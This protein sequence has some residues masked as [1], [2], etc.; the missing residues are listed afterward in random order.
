MSITIRKF[1]SVCR[2]DSLAVA[3]LCLLPLIAV[4]APRLLAY[5]P[6]LAG[7]IGV[8]GFWVRY[9][10]WPSIPLNLALWLAAF[11]ALAALSSL[12]A[13]DP[14]FALERSGKL[15]P[16][17]LGGVLVVSFASH[18]QPS[19][20][21][22]FRFLFP[23]GVLAA[24]VLC[25]LNL[26]A[27]GA[28][29]SI[30]HGGE[31]GDAVNPSF[32]NR[33]VVFFTLSLFTAFFALC[34]SGDAKDRAGRRE[35]FSKA[36]GLALGLVSIAILFKTQSQSAQLALLGGAAAFLLFPY[37]TKGAWAVLG[38]LI[39]GAMLV[40]PFAAHAAF[41]HLASALYDMAWFSKGYAADR[42]EIWDYV[43]RRA[44]EQPLHGFGIEATRA[45]TDFDT[46]Q[47]YS[48]TKGVLHPHN[49]TLQLWIEF[50]LP[51]V[52]L[53]GA[54]IGFILR[55]IGTLPGRAARVA[56]ATFIATLCVASTGYGLWQGW[57]L[58]SF[59][60]LA[61]FTVIAGKM[62]AVVEAKAEP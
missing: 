45:I 3:L 58:G 11:I 29:Y 28:L 7:L 9:K 61:A 8:L 14:P 31:P 13:I 59:A 48:P 22:L 16:V 6:G 24:G 57:W 39:T 50:G 38:V 12:W 35:R 55:K 23:V 19:D 36:I 54:F 25:V 53:A 49:F 46:Q 43:S 37:R 17:F 34:A 47:L 18:A 41:Q 42:L 32:F 62:G 56:L 15:L 20:I 40:L 21:R 26:Y 5:L 4:T 10:T 27:G 1:S 30:L 33:G 2:A 60:A 51:G 44:L 52:L